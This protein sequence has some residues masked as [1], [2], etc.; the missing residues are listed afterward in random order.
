MDP[1][2]CHL[3]SRG[4]SMWTVKKHLVVVGLGQ[5]SGS[6]MLSF[7]LHAGRKRKTSSFWCSLK[8]RAILVIWLWWRISKSGVSAWEW[9]LHECYWACFGKREQEGRREE[10]LVALRAEAMVHP[11]IY[12][13]FALHA[14][15]ANAHEPKAKKKFWP[16]SHVVSWNVAGVE[17]METALMQRERHSFICFCISPPQFHQPLSAAAWSC[18]CGRQVL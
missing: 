15:D 7:C 5:E 17:A 8:T 13:W 10:D 14:S 2:H 6:Y 4:R 11:Y 9:I 18:C 3:P 1:S 12:W 16:L